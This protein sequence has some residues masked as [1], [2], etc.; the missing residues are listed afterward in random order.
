MFQNIQGR[1]LFIVDLT[2]IPELPI[3]DGGIK[4]L[5][6]YAEALDAAIREGVITEP[7]K[8]GIEIDYVLNRWNIHTIHE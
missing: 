2:E 3:T 1:K 6:P 7:G 8:Y 5:K 4:A